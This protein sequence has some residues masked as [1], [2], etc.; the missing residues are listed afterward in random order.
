[1]MTSK[2]LARLLPDF[3]SP[4]TY[5]ELEKTPCWMQ[6]ALTFLKLQLRIQIFFPRIVSRCDAKTKVRV[7]YV[8]GI[9]KGNTFRRV[10]AYWG[11]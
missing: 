2:L 4:E 1:M 3:M 10:T 11:Q 6:S 5:N 9:S 7:R 8:C